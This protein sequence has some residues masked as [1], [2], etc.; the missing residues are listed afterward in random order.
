MKGKRFLLGMITLGL[1]AG[2]T[3]GATEPEGPDSRP[4][5]NVSDTVPA[6]SVAGTPTGAA[7]NGGLFGSGT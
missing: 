2:C 4:R 6:D 1:A 7:F 3:R 5:Y